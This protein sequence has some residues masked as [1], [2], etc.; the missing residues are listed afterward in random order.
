MGAAVIA[1]I[2]RKEKDVVDAFRDAGAT[3]ATLSRPLNEVG[4]DQDVGFRRLRMHEVIRE[5]RPGYF[6]LDDPVW[7]AVRSTRRRIATVLL[8]VIVL[9]FLGGTFGWFTFK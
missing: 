2:M 5:A 7:H 1:V 6:Y 4:V 8:L 9:A 3:S